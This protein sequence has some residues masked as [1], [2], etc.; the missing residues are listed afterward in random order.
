MN[1]WLKCLNKIGKRKIINKTIIKIKKEINIQALAG[2]TSCHVTVGCRYSQN[3]DTW[4]YCMLKVV[5]YFSNRR[6]KINLTIRDMYNSFTA[7][8]KAA[9]FELSWGIDTP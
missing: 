8:S 4:K 9:Y 1:L 5:E 6:Y 3:E 7:D 2:N